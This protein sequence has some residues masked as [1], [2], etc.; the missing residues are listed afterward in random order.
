MDKV[1]LGGFISIKSVLE[2]KSRPIYK[3][4]IE[5][6]RFD[7]VM[8]SDLRVSEQRQYSALINAGVE[9]S[10]ISQEEFN[11]IMPNA[12]ARPTVRTRIVCLEMP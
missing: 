2:S 9:Y 8:R 7:N 10:L 4:F 3:I 11:E 1:I 5:R 6:T 12:N